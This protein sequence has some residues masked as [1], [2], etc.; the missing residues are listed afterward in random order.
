MRRIYSYHDNDHST[1]IKLKMNTLLRK[2]VIV[3]T[4]WGS[5]GRTSSDQ[6]VDVKKDAKDI[7]DSRFNELTV[8]EILTTRTPEQCM[9]INME[10]ANING[11]VPLIDDKYVPY[12]DSGST[13]KDILF[14]LVTDETIV[15]AKYLGEFMGRKDPKLITIDMIL[16]KDMGHFISIYNKVQGDGFEDDRKEQKDPFCNML[17]VW[18]ESNREPD[19]PPPA[20]QECKD[21]MMKMYDEQPFWG[22]NRD[23]LESIL[24]KKSCSYSVAVLKVYEKRHPGD[25]IEDDLYHV[26]YDDDL[27]F[28]YQCMAGHVKDRIKLFAKLLHDFRDRGDRYSVWIL[29]IA[30][31]RGENIAKIDAAFKKDYGG[32]SL[33]SF[34][35]KKTGDPTVIEI[36]AKLVDPNHKLSILAPSPPGPPG[37]V[38]PP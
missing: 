22:T 7:V 11:G 16:V 13:Y 12:K 2:L 32:E 28:A 3:F 31:N 8:A 25:D 5:V 23:V 38:P 20:E 37:T 33:S 26:L 17:R 27:L 4:F 19:G 1:V 6:C 24:I 34:I 18:A 36:L 10:I 35:L 29:I 30:L 9:Q 14:A 21:V 15:L